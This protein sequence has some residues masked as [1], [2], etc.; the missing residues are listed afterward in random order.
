MA[1]ELVIPMILIIIET[2]VLLL[3]LSCGMPKDREPTY[4]KNQ[5][6]QFCYYVP[7]EPCPTPV[8]NYDYDDDSEWASI[9]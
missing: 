8:P 4:T 5:C 3:L 1:R 9:E 2:I 7:Q 6:S